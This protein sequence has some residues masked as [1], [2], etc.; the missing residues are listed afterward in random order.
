MRTEDKAAIKQGLR[1]LVTLLFI[2]FGVFLTGY[3][4]GVV[5]E[6]RKAE[7]K[8]TPAVKV[9]TLWRVDTVKVPHPVPVTKW[10]KDTTY[11]PVTDTVLVQRND[12]TFLPVPV[13]TTRYAGEDY[14][15]WVSGFRASLDSI[16]IF[17]PTAVVE[18]QVPVYINKRWGIGLQAGVTWTK[19]TKFAPYVGVGVSYNILSF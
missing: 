16:N 19:D 18:K 3:E 6:Q 14:E 1:D 12:T 8:G 9:D 15:A 10:L 5:H 4:A 11:I 7:G 13:E 2:F 17:R